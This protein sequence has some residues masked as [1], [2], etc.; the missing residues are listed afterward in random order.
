MRVIVVDA[1]GTIGKAVVPALGTR[2]EI[3]PGG[4]GAGG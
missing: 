4:A 1:S 2:Y 3:V